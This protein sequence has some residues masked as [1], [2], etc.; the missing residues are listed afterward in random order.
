MRMQ[1]SA[2]RSI[3]VKVS[4]RTHHDQNAEYTNIHNRLGVRSQLASNNMTIEAQVAVKAEGP[5]GVSMSNNRQVIALGFD[6]LTLYYA[7]GTGWSASAF[8][9]FED[10]NPHDRLVGAVDKA[11]TM[12]YIDQIQN[13][14]QDYQNLIQ[15]F[16]LDLGQPENTM[17]TNELIEASRMGKAKEEESY[18]EAL[19]VQYGRYLLIASS[20]PGS[21]PVSGRSVWSRDVNSPVDSPRYTPL[22]F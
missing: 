21:L 14:I 19:M 12:F 17:A 13:H 4:I 2:P 18:L 5:T 20:R 9:D 15:G 8:P 11:T 16:G 6:T 22:Y 10:K 1:S 3:N 7:F